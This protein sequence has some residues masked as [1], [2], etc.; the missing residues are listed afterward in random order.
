MA[1]ATKCPHCNTTFRVAHDQLKLRG[2]IVR[3]GACNEVFDGNAALVDPAPR[4]PVIIDLP[5][6]V[7][8]T[9]PAAVAAP[10]PSDAAPDTG[11][12]DALPHAE[13]EV[14]AEAAPIAEAAPE[15]VHELLPEPA[16]DAEP[17]PAPELA[18]EPDFDLDLNGD[19]TPAPAA[20]MPEP[21]PADTAEA[22]AT[23]PAL[24][25]EHDD[26]FDL[27]F[28]IDV[29]HPAPDEALP[30]DDDVPAQPDASADVLAEPAF[31]EHRF[32]GRLEP[33][34]EIPDEH[35]AAVALHDSFELDAYPHAHD[36]ELHSTDERGHTLDGGVWRNRDDA[37]HLGDEPPATAAPDAHP[38]HSLAGDD[39]DDDDIV[40]LSSAAA[41][42][43]APEPA[44]P[45]TPVSAR[46][47]EEPGFV[48][49]S[50]RKEQ[51]GKAS[52]IAM[53]CALPLLLAGLAYQAVA[54]FRNPLAAA[55]P[56]LKPALVAGCALIGCKVELPSQLDALSIDQG[57]L[58][59]M[60]D[61]IFS[62]ATS[63]RNQSATAQSWPHIELILNDSAD[64]PVLRRV[65]APRD[66]LPPGADAASGFLPRS[67]QPVKLYFEL[68]R[69]KASGY[70]IAVF[71]P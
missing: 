23:L 62:F 49:R 64:K 60:A 51:W 5:D 66:Y 8:D 35:L 4:T 32:D 67:E 12:A 16:P 10:A 54:T 45:A 55:V 65:F 43:L 69:V 36:G 28:N 19:E 37:H 53:A 15:P 40:T 31:D 50:R 26:A 1:L 20:P 70:H 18:Q 38:V 11:T 68:S 13:D 29:D 27:D 25:K 42:T 22:T 30:V 2:G 17:E 14:V 21:A 48:K 52:R 24:G 9:A 41:A 46:E 34:L 6:P 44:A 7:H 71:Y 56:A 3:C 58:Q 33:T 59:T 39:G 61:N 57:E 47:P 63:L